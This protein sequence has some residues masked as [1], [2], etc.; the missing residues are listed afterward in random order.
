MFHIAMSYLS[1]CLILSNCIIWLDEQFS[2]QKVQ[3][4]ELDYFLNIEL[5]KNTSEIIFKVFL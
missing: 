4:C 2:E 3:I 1:L 5:Q